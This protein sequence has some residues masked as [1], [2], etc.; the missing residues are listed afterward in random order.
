MASILDSLDDQALI[1][2]LQSYRH[3]GRQGYSIRA[4]WRACLAKFLLK[5]RYT[6]QLTERLRGSRKFR[7][8]CGFDDQVPSDSAM[9]RF[10]TRLNQHQDIVEKILAS[11]TDEIRNLLPKTVVA[12]DGK[13]HPAIPVGE[14]VAID[15]T[16]FETFSNPNRK[17]ISDPDAAWGLKHSSKAKEGGE[18]FA[19]GYKMH[20]VSDAVYGVPLDFI[21]T[22]ANESDSPL[23]PPLMDKAKQSHPW[24][25]SKYL[26]GDRGYDS[27]RNHKYLI[28]QGIVPVIH[29]RKAPEGR[30]YDGIYD[31]KGRP[32]CIGLRPMEYVRTDR[33]TGQHLFKCTAEGCPL[34]NKGTKGTLHCN[35]TV[36]ENPKTNVR[37]IGILHRRQS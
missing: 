10:N 4:M 20:L 27:T 2:V 29:M 3:T 18:E 11:A 6:N 8:I 17:V 34:K 22:P 25:E 30:L 1:E 26:L 24:L 13:E 37:V 35:D 33:K 12:P 28:R 15:S 32:T 16:V 19:F 36:W 9:S 7:T 21:I 5:I 31:E 23:L 14:V